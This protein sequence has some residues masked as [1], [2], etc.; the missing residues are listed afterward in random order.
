MGEGLLGSSL[1]AEEE[2]RT[3][4]A[5]VGAEA[6]AV[7][8]AASL[9]NQN[10]EVA[11]ET[12]A[13][14][15]KQTELLEA[16]RKTV[17]TEHEFF[18]VE[19]GPRLLGI[20]LRIAFQVFAAIAATVIGVGV[21]VMIYDAVKSHNVV[22]DAFDIAPNLSGEVPSGKIVAAGLLD[23]LTRIQAATRSSAEH[24]SLSNAW[25]ND[26]AIEVPETGI[27]L[28][29]LERIL[30]TR[31]G[32]DQHID[33][34][35][36]PTEK[37]GLALS[38]RGN[39]ILPKTFT[40]AGRNIESLLTQA[41]EYAYGQSQPALWANY[42][43]NAG[44]YDDAIHF[45]Q[46]NYAAAGRS[47]RPYLLNYWA[48]AIVGKGDVGANKEALILWRESVRLKPDYWIGYF[49]VMAG[50]Q[51]TGDEEGA[52]R[53]GEQMI[54]LAGGRFGR[55]DE[56]VFQNYDDLVW[57]LPA[58]LASSLADMNIN[59]GFGTLGTPSG[60]EDLSVAGIEVLM[61]D[62][63]AAALRLKTTQ[64]DPQNM[65][66]V[67]NATFDRARLAEELGDFQSAAR[68][69]DNFAA[70]YA[71][72]TV[73]T[74]VPQ[75]ICFA[76]ITFEKTGQ[77]AKADAALDAVGKLTLVDCY[78]FR[79]DLHDLR[80]DWTG[81][82]EWY[83]KTV[84]LGPSIPSGYYSWGMALAKHGNLEGAMDKF[85][86]ANR[87]GPHWADPLKAWG[88]VLVKQAKT[89]EAIRKY[90]EAL[91]YAPNWQELKQAREG[92]VAKH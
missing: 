52:V 64:F 62:A 7:A 27:S 8:V 42:L 6:F 48:D 3:A 59:S 11:A 36:V 51:G 45:C 66:D 2:Q 44:R 53:V 72:P 23:V 9:S 30:R 50:L 16:Q 10:P 78:R 89:K 32:H 74:N 28:G 17:E 90:D 34:D 41:G 19:W 57:D 65:V 71:N 91:K 29:Q 67:A 12:V 73:Q 54:R 77:P 88:D 82:Q 76:A 83:A 35:L 55:A 46:A 38:V 31:F 1:L 81:A 61:H 69:W 70:A 15:R 87:K 21:I 79:A 84:Q 92:L 80:G 47:E 33:G 60:S 49:N 4:S 5:D 68:D 22:I 25:T 63:E 86:D 20:R 43:F 18:E 24:R 58:T 37:G 40:D 14:L 26:I 75:S 13:F 56:Y 85:S 39:G